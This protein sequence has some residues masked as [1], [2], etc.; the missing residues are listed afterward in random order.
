MYSVGRNVI[1]QYQINKY[2]IISS[3]WRKNVESNYF[4]L[5]LCI[6]YQIRYISQI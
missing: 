5:K 2:L 6:N 4:V 1:H 3:S